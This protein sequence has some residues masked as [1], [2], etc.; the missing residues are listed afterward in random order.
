MNEVLM[1]IPALLVAIA[2]VAMIIWAAHDGRRFRERFPPISDVE[3]LARC[4]PGT[5][6][7]VAL[8]VRRIVAQH[9]AVEYERVYPETCFVEDL[10]AD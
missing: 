5:N 2:F 6:P 1:S 8:K 7:E 4:R 3:F 10:G 9:F